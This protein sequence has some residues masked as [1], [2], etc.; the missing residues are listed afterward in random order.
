M[1]KL[2]PYVD[3]LRSELVTHNLYHPR[4]EMMIINVAQARLLADKAMEEMKGQRVM[5]H[6]TGAQGQT[7]IS[8]NP[9]FEQ[10]RKLLAVVIS[11]EAKLGLGNENRVEQQTESELDKFI[12]ELQ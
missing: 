2:K 8:I 6:Q 1:K 4:N 11:G 12:R 3:R 10:L 5:L 9:L 7:K